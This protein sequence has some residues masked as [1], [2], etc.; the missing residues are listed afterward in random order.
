[1]DSIAIVGYSFKLPGGCEDDTSFW[2][3]LEH[4][5]NV[6]TPWPKSRSNLDA[7]YDPASR[8]KNTLQSRGAH[9]VKE[10]SAAFDA[11][12]F[13]ISS[14]E[15]A[16]MDPQQRWLLEESYRAFE[17]AGMPVEKIAGSE[18]AVFVAS[19]ADD[20]MRML[21]KDPDEA[22]T[23]TATGT[24]PSILANRLS[25][26]FD[27][28][29][30]S[31]QLNTACSSSMIA[32]DLA[33]QSLH[34]GQSSM[35]LV[36]GAN[37][38]LNPE[39]SLYLSNMNFLSPDGLC[40][41]FDQR[42]NGYSRGEGV[43]VLLLKKLPDAIRDGDMIR[44]VIRATGSNQDGHTPGLT[45]PSASAQEE[46]IRKVYE[47][48]NLDFE[49]T[50]Y[51]EAHGTGTQIGDST[52][53][54]ALGRVFRSARSESEPLY[55]GSVKANIGHLEGG[56]GLAGIMK[57]IVVLEKG[58]I[59]PNALFEKL[60][61]QINS[62]L[63]RVKVPTACIPWPGNRLRRMSLNSFGFGGSNG[64]VVMDDAYHTLEALALRGNHHTLV[65]SPEA[66]AA[67]DN[68]TKRHLVN[69]FCHNGTGIRYT[70]GTGCVS[71][72][73]DNHDDKSDSLALR[74]DASFV[75]GSIHGKPNGTV[76]NNAH[77]AVN[78]HD[79]EADRSE[80][81]KFKLLVW[82]AKDKSAVQRL[83]QQYA[84][85]A[86]SQL[87]GPQ[88]TLEKLSFTLAA[89]RMRSSR[90][91]ALSFVF[92]GQG[93]QYAGMGVFT[94]L[95]A[96]WSLF[97]EIQ[98]KQN[99]NKPQF[100][101]P[102]CTALQIALIA[103]LE[104]F[105]IVPSAVVGHSSGEIA[106]AYCVGGLS[107]ESACKVAYRRGRLTGDL[108]K[109]TEVPGAMMSVNIREGDVEAY[110]SRF[111]LNA[112]VH[113][114]CVNSPFNVT[115]SGDESDIDTLKKH[116]DDDGAFAQKLTT[117]V[118]YHSP[119]MRRISGEY[120]SCLGQ[121]EEGD[122]ERNSIL[123]VSSVTGQREA[124][125]A[126]ASGQ[127]WVDNMVSPVRFADA[128][129]YLAAVAPKADG[130]KTV[131]DFIEVGP[132]GA[133][134]RPVNDT[135]VHIGNNKASRYAALLSKL[136]S[137]VK[138]IM[139][140]AGQLFSQGFPVSV[141]A[142]NKQEC[143][144]HGAPFA[145]DAPPY[146][147]DHSQLY[148]AA[149]WNPLEPRWRKI[150]SA[151]EIPWLAD[152]VVGQ[153][154]F[155]PAAG[156][157]VMAL[158]AV[159]QADDGPKTISAYCIKD[160]VFKTPIVIP[161][162]GKTEVVTQLRRL[163][164]SHAK[165]S[166]RCEVR[167]FTNSDDCW[168]ECFSAIVHVEYEETP[169][170][171][172][173]GR[174]AR[175]AAEDLSH[176][177]AWH[178]EQGLKYGEAFALADEI[179]W[180][181]GELGVASVHVGPPTL[182]FEGIV[183]PAVLD[184]SC[185]VCFVAPSGGM[186]KTLPTIIPH[187]ISQAWV[188]AK[189]WQYPETSHIR[190]MTKSRLKS[191]SSGIDSSFIVVADS[192][193]PLCHMEHLDMLPVQGRPETAVSGGRRLLHGIDWKPHLSLLSRDQL[194]EHCDVDALPDDETAAAN[195]CIRLKKAL[196]AVV[197][198]E[199]TKLQETDWTRAPSHM[200]KFVSW[201]ERELERNPIADEDE[202][203]RE[204]LTNELNH[205]R[206]MRPSARMFI[207]IAENLVSI[208]RGEIDVVAFLFSTP[209]A[210]D[211]YDTLFERMNNHK[212]E[213]YVQL[214]AHQNPSQRILEVGSGTGGMTSVL[215]S[216]LWRI[217]DRTGGIA[218]SEYVYTD[219]STGFFEKARERFAEHQ[220]RMTFK[221]LDLE[222]DIIA[223]GYEAGSYDVIFAGSVL[224]ATKN[225]NATLQNLRCVL[226]PGGRLVFHETT[227]PDC[228]V[229]CFG[230]GPLTGW[231]YSEEDFRTWAPTITLPEWDR[232]LRE[233]GFSGNDMVIR[234]YENDDA[235]WASII[236][237]TLEYTPE[238]GAEAPKTLLVVDDKDE[239]Q[240]AVAASLSAALADK[241][242]HQ[243][244]TL[245]LENLE[246]RHLSSVDF[247]LF[248]AEMGQSC[249]VD[250]SETNFAA[251]QT[252]VNVSK[253]LLW[254]TSP[255]RGSFDSTTAPPYG[256]LKDGFLRTLRSEH[257]EKRIVSL[258]FE[259][260][261]L[262]ASTA[263]DQIVKI[264]KSAFG[265][266]SPEDE[267]VILDGKVLTGRLVQETDMNRDMSSSLVPQARLEPWLPGPPLKVETES[268]G[269][270]ETLQ[271][272][273]DV[274]YYEP[275][276]PEEVEIEAKAWGVN[277]RDVF[278]ALGRLDE[279]GFGSDC[280]GIVTKVGS[281]CTSVKAGD[282]VVMG[283]V[284]CMRMFPRGEESAVCKIPES[285][286]FEE[287]C[288]ILN[289][290]ITAWHSLVEVA[291]L[292]KGERI[293]IHA[294]SGATGQLA[295][296]IAQMIG[297][298]V[299]AT[300]GFNH[301][302]QL[303]MDQYGIPE[304]H[305]LYSRDTSFAKGV[306][307][308]TRGYGV[309]VVLNSL[310]GEGLFASLKCVAPHGRFIEIGK[311][312]INANSSL[313]M[314]FFANNVTFSAV[315]LRYVAL[316]NKDMGRR[317]LLKTMELAEEGQI[318]CPKPL[319][320]YGLDTLQEGFRYLQSGKNTGRIV[321]RIDPCTTVEKRLINRRA[322]T[323][324]EH[325]T[326]LIAGGLGGLGRSMMKW[327]A[328]KGAK[329][330]VV[331]TRSGIASQEAADVVDELGKQGVRVLTPTCD[332]SSA[333]CLAEALENCN[334]TMPPIRGCI[335]AAMVLQDSVFENMT[336]AQWRQTIRSK[337]DSSLHLH[338]L[339][340]DGLDFF[341]LLSSAAGIVGNVSQSNYAAG[342][343]FQDALARHRVARGQH[344][345]SIDLGLMR[346]IGIVAESE[347]LRKNFEGSRSLAKI[348]E[349][350]FL[351]VLDICCSPTGRPVGEALRSQVTVG[352]VTPADLL[353]IE[354]EPDETLQRP[355]FAYFSRL[356]GVSSGSSSTN[357]IDFAALFH[358][359]E[360]AEERAT[361]VTD[362]L[363]T[364]LA[365]SLS[366]QPQ[367]I[368]VDQPN[369][370]YGVDSLVAVELRNWI[371]KNFAA[372]MS[373]FEITGGK[374]VAALAE[375]V[376]RKSQIPSKKRSNEE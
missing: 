75:N 232:V 140:I 268:R 297:A 150:L 313:P 209:L 97:A 58:L 2:D 77:G 246:K 154:I 117:G 277:F 85:Y 281:Q 234:D 241:L 69:R 87:T 137:P 309:D 164:Q 172:D 111:P 44:A 335:N 293:L 90:Q 376:T 21:T 12:F 130:L 192:G 133:L 235:H 73:A 42:A 45:Q 101:Q 203:S 314:A 369:H 367:D 52:E 23:N 67:S 224:H 328:Q 139:T 188:S 267:Y 333:Q 331:P 70:N 66:S 228:F 136:V 63:Y 93:A 341:I 214:S 189:G 230:F 326:Y 247:V 223:Q 332:V 175:L 108:V 200:R 370:N 298:E 98:S 79:E 286:S 221:P 274:V 51:V 217:E 65:L 307:R 299:F 25:W 334:A 57:G 143:G 354:M 259:G 27:L 16:S 92:T 227:A 201:M 204:A 89:R 95:G 282:R 364:K 208:V 258:S 162:E 316:H 99:I 82:S 262:A 29:G 374:S 60:N 118:A 182:P 245:S 318:Y 218:F 31:L 336:H 296:Q 294:A 260:G 288:G 372:N 187:R 264:L 173:G 222:K 339:L 84:T 129:Q 292:Q 363:A 197:Q 116:L 176:F 86:E 231:W 142:V 81:A 165:S 15:A 177:Y 219:I 36:A 362:A 91:T 155:F 191:N 373:V 19:M 68:A 202:M 284:G 211:L 46:L 256:G 144:Q 8:K 212:L 355:L 184:A 174:E 76:T 161:V 159:N 185:Q 240:L 10:D 193:S 178:E 279:E 9:F 55:V 375:L 287:A 360:S 255:K 157:L 163:Q 119:A 11:S 153:T 269:S 321:I 100:S 283:A 236:V 206:E 359:A 290:G 74:H 261:S 35:A 180:D 43:V 304:D 1:M 124:P 346:T 120:L 301:K 113:V 315:D 253:N 158:E 265:A 28:K 88:E 168:S 238:L 357:A 138:S 310:V 41:S 199:M 152:H 338:D 207:E 59:P 337:V 183:H 181:G 329:H 280:A 353:Q 324:D 251:M 127:Y 39:S 320:I 166:P 340:G 141:V 276:G 213:S 179:H 83:L 305:I 105:H 194:Q 80:P 195:Y 342:C 239:Y 112:A 22:P 102:I 6:M 167:L 156:S 366:M 56:S 126:M 349:D 48:E 145:V 20:Y 5:R 24:A 285:V 345:V 148:W 368:D 114:A 229:I 278:L 311:A 104:S 244:E 306:M 47:N 149:D 7:F 147:F 312:D 252:C 323:F 343:T 123:L 33:C 250:I 319:H 273:E 71:H 125:K 151:E 122:G 14:K 356:R 210:Q 233:N 38:L 358:Q 49:S 249:L 289:S 190:T 205:L 135:L 275:L 350:E 225:L 352:L 347:K 18:T 196:I 257:L 131:S 3:M 220:D 72:V 132:H 348:E 109:S 13:S 308:V 237:S 4:G 295:I 186:S 365:R 325:A 302:R 115:L 62:K 215:L 146:P 103:L 198:H 322:W 344:A 37:V 242:V 371:A 271:Y 248:L 54:K 171:V 272:V 291:R 17:N 134:R 361:I 121:L 128:I 64:H 226:R 303:L 170:E 50:R 351:T 327:M 107:L 330:L 106:A 216:Y 30:P 270:L 160:A 61:P 34:N 266:A 317:L 53:M 300:V 94:Q 96:D 254:V 243:P 40:Y 78:G 110:L 169:T 32:V 26:Y 263:A